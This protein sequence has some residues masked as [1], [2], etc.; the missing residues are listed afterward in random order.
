MKITIRTVLLTLTFM[1]SYPVGQAQT[2]S[3]EKHGWKLVFVTWYDET[4]GIEKTDKEYGRPCAVFYVKDYPYK[5]GDEFPKLLDMHMI[6][7]LTVESDDVG[8]QIVMSL[9]EYDCKKRKYRTLKNFMSDGSERTAKEGEFIGWWEDILEG[10]PAD[11]M[12]KYACRP[13]TSPKQ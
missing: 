13:R 8:L 11:A 1:A 5:A 7:A 9:S 2:P 3:I 10:A 12:L 4:T 6:E